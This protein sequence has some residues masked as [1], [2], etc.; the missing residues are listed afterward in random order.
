M[1]TTAKNLLVIGPGHLGA[2][3]ATL[4]QNRF[5][6]AEIALK[7][8]REDPERDAKWQSLG[9]TPFKNGDLGSKQYENVLFAAPP[10]GKKLKIWQKLDFVKNIGLNIMSKS[11][12]KMTQVCK[13]RLKIG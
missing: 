12:K 5:P 7:A 8:H 9:F 2:R 13:Y 11:S 3:V 1:S 6:E 10:K 4:W